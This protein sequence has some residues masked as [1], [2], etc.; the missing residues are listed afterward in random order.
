MEL[1]RGETDPLE[2]EKGLA[3]FLSLS[4]VRHFFKGILGSFE[5]AANSAISAVTS[6]SS[7]ADG[8]GV[9]SA[10]TTPSKLARLKQW[11]QKRAATSQMNNP[12]REVEEGAKCLSS[13]NPASLRLQTIEAV[14]SLVFV[15]FGDLYEILERTNLRGREEI[16][17]RLQ[18]LVNG[19]GSCGTGAAAVGKDVGNVDSSRLPFDF[20]ESVVTTLKSSV[21]EIE[22]SRT[23]MM[24]DMERGVVDLPALER[25]KELEA[26]LTPRKN[27]VV[28][29]SVNARLEY[30]KRCFE[31]VEMRIGICRDSGGRGG[32]DGGGGGGGE[33]N[34]DGRGVGVVGDKAFD[35]GDDIGDEGDRDT[36][37]SPVQRAASSRSTWSPT[38]S[39]SRSQTPLT[40]K[41]RLQQRMSLPPNLSNSSPTT[42]RCSSPDAMSI[43]TESL[44]SYSCFDND[45]IFN[46]NNVLHSM[47]LLWQPADTLLLGLLERGDFESCWRMAQFLKCDD[48]LFGVLIHKRLNSTGE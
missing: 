44:F 31:E 7:G 2:H 39:P 13:I 12:R 42:S 48:S 25:E 18:Y 11:R 46:N 41:Q 14:F 15:S 3:I 34:G 36:L 37:H 45:G 6:A 30:L 38:A 19:G 16:E 32:G 43:S 9:K 27:I 40:P 10:N 24:R 5:I 35:G 22:E 17:F 47:L 28:N 26:L 33:E 29:K 23:K 21:E 20:L 4:V 8:A 1:N